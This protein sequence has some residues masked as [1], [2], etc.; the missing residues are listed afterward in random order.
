MPRRADFWEACRRGFHNSVKR[1]LS[2]GQ[3]PNEVKESDTPLLIAVANNHTQIVW[4]LID[5]GADVNLCVSSDQITPLSKACSLGHTHLVDMLLYAGANVHIPDKHSRSSLSCA[6]IHQNLY[7]AKRLLEKG[8]NGNDE[9]DEGNNAM[10][11]AASLGRN[12]EV[13]N[14]LLS[15]GVNLYSDDKRETELHVAARSGNMTMAIAFIQAGID[16]NAVYLSCITPLK[17]A[18]IRGFRG[19]VEM[20]LAMGATQDMPNTDGMTPLECALYS[21]HL[22]VAELLILAGAIFNRGE[23]LQFY[24]AVKRHESLYNLIQ[25]VPLP[26]QTLTRMQLHLQ[27]MRER[28]MISL[29]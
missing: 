3:N 18:S 6:V 23:I 28:F 29:K 7:I 14:L 10:R 12:P 4:M 5:A 16:V 9:D 26:L 17:L 8:A 25:S 2:D 24:S 27:E 13:V 22:D 15:Y 21:G 11:V 20:L 19:M 1:M